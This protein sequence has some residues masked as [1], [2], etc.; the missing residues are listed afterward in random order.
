MPRSKSNGAT[1]A[2]V[3]KGLQALVAT[4]ANESKRKDD[5]TRADWAQIDASL[6]VQTVVA[7]TQA[8][9]AVLFGTDTT[10]FGYV[11][12]IFAQGAKASKWFRPEAEAHHVLYE[13]LEAVIAASYE[14]E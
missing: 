3:R 14:S 11:V 2:P 9:G 7:V 1:P 6:I 10:G 13:Y 12:T 4:T 5:G 8:G